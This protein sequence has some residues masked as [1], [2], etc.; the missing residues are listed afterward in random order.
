MNL[1][2]LSKVKKLFLQSF[3]DQGGG[4]KDELKLARQAMQDKSRPYQVYTQYIVI[5]LI[6]LA[7]FGGN[8]DADWGQVVDR[9]RRDQACRSD[10]D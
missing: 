2:D 10:F 5:P 9:H 7:A 3:N 6:M 4:M 1:T 8:F